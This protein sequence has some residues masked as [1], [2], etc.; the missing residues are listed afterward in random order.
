MA[1]KG[2]E[3]MMK[4]GEERRGE[5]RKEGKVWLMVVVMMDMVR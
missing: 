5:E 1:G 3:L 2:M 4:E